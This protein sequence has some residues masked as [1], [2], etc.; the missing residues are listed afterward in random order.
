M[1]EEKQKD[2][3]SSVILLLVSLAVKET[4][5]NCSD[6][7]EFINRDHRCLYLQML[8]GKVIYA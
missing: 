8:T 5:V 6:P 4:V 2:T 3:S 1:R 7:D